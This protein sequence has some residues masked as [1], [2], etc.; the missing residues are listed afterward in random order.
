MTSKAFKICALALALGSAV[1]P[2]TAQAHSRYYYDRYGH[3][4]YYSSNYDYHHRHYYGP[5]GRRSCR[6]EKRARSTNGSVIGGLT[7]G[8]LGAAVSHGSLGGALIGGSVGAIAGHE[9]G[10]SGV[11]C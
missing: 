9:I 6:G 11:N 1:A 7:G 2:L 10:R 3:R 8:T 4:H 5:D